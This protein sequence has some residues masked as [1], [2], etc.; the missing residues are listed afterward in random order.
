MSN[1]A[2]GLII[3]IS[4]NSKYISSDVTLLSCTMNKEKLKIYK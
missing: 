1:A 3:D 4:N 2:I